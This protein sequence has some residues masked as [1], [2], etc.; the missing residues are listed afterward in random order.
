MGIETKV[1]M[2]DPL[3]PERGALE[4]ACRIL[5]AGGLVAFPTDTLYALGVDALK[6]RAVERVFSA[7]GRRLEKPLT[8]LVADLA[9]VEQVA[10]GIPSRCLKL[11]ASFWPGPLTLILKASPR[12]PSN[13]T[14]GTGQVGVRVPGLPLARALV[15]ELGRPLTGSSA[16]LSGHRDPRDAGDVLQDLRGRIELVLDGGRVPLGVPST[17][18]D[19]VAEPPALLREGAISGSELFKLLEAIH[20]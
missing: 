19:L 12:L 17:I 7:K 3:D 6:E 11:T 14:A 10:A 5:R 1:L 20:G 8:V 15:R 9:M 16:N 18:L 4:E 2:V 13:L